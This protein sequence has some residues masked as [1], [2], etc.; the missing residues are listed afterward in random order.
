MVKE[1]E[2]DVHH[3]SKVEMKETKEGNG[4]LEEE[5]RRY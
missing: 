3:G 4:G 5:M 2:G 1:E